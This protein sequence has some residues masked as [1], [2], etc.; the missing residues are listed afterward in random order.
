MLKIVRTPSSWRTGTTKRVARWWAGANMKPKPASS[1]QRATPSGVEVD[2]RAERLQHVGRPGGAGGGAVAVLGHGAPRA[3]GDQRGGGGDVERASPPT[4][5]RGVEQVLLRAWHARG[6]L[7]HRARHARQ[8]LN[9]L[10]LG[11]Q[12]NQEAGDLGL[13]DLAVHDLRQHLG[14]LSFAQVLARCERV[15]RARE[16]RVGHQSRKLLNSCLPSSVSTDSGWNCTPSA[17][18]SRWRSAISTPSPSAE[19]SKQAGSSRS[20][21]SEW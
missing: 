6:E 18:S 15:D 12:R 19:A 20:T 16:D 4:G 11:A 9:S 5:A 21:I 8:L 1:M 13:G 17:G 2:A 10:A 7:A 14:S 3:R